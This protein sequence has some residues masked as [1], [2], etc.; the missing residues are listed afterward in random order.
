ML[1]WKNLLISGAPFL[2]YL[3]IFKYYAFLREITGLNDYSKPNREILPFLDRT[4]FQCLP[5]RVLSSNPNTVLDFLA[6]VPYLVHFP[7]PILFLV[8]LYFSHRRRR[9]IYAFL[10]CAGWVNLLAVLVQFLFPTAPPWFTDTAVFDEKGQFLGSGNNEAG[11]ERLDKLLHMQMFHNIY[12]ASPV[13]FGAMPSLHVAWP[14]IILVCRPWISSQFGIFHVVWIAW[15][16][17]YSNHHY[18]V[19]AMAGI[20]LALLVNVC[21]MRI[22]CPFPPVSIFFNDDEDARPRGTKSPKPGSFLPV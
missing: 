3:L 18:G 21:M 5:H 9:Q 16:A 11:F 8:Y 15:A 20:L 10:W 1:E 12:S 7:L 4:I 17:M 6:A 2:G 22:Y 14:A 13:K 19:D